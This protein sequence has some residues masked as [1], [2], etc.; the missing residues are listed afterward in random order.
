MNRKTSEGHRAEIWLAASHPVGALIIVLFVPSQDR[1]GND[2]DHD[3]WSQGRL[4]HWAHFFE[5]RR[6][7]RVLGAFGAM[8]SAVARC[9]MNNRLSSLAT[10]ILVP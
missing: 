4:R 2:I 6:L 5:G 10:L 3:F 9:V 1:D 7:F 8:M